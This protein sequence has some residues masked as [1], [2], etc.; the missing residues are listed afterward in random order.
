MSAI[1]YVQKQQD[2]SF[3]GALRMV[4]LRADLQISPNRHK[5]GEQPD[6]LVRANQTEIGAGWVRVGEVS[7]REYIRLAL[8]APELGARTIYVN[9]GRAAGQEDDDTYA[10]I[11]NPG[12]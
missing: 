6:Y 12:E 10:L 4:S 5:T 3:T 1:G 2:G 8:S 11:W 7:Q 9:L